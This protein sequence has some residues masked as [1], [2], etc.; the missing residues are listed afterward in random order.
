MRAMRTNLVVDI[1]NAIKCHSFIVSNIFLD[2]KQK[3]NNSIKQ[4]TYPNKFLMALIV[5]F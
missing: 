3:N 1:A 5:E 2:P 4:K